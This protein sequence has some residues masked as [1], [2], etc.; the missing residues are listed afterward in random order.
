MAEVQTQDELL[1]EGLGM[2][3]RQPAD[4]GIADDVAKEISSLC[5]LHRNGQILGSQEYLQKRGE[6]LQ[7][8]HFQLVAGIILLAISPV[9]PDQR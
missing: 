5:I 6:I 8:W 7:M 2:I 9:L 4:R 3:F 1:E